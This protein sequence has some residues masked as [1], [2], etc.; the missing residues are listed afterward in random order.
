MLFSLTALIDSG[1]SDGKAA[2]GKV[3]D[4]MKILKKAG[5]KTNTY[6]PLCAYAL[7]KNSESPEDYTKIPER[8]LEL[9]KI[10]KKNHPILTSRE[11]YLLSLLMALVP[12]RTA[13]ESGFKM[14]ENYKALN[15]AGF[16]KGNQ[17][18][19]MSHILTLDKG[20]A[21]I[22]AGKCA[23]I[24]KYLKENK[25][26]VSSYG[27]GSLALLTILSMKSMDAVEKVVEYS[28]TLRKTKGFRTIGKYERLLHATALTGHEL[29]A[30][31]NFEMITGLTVQTLLLAQQIAIMAAIVVVC[32]SSSASAAS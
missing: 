8:G 25:I 19:F 12:G 16:M 17:L 30:D 11:D 7:E 9:F 20:D 21:Q 24:R 14:E 15:D 29:S 10:M 32:A 22:K 26:R 3:V 1:F 28:Q 27:D 13:G 18:Q 4:A 23:E 31:S 5:Y 6:L 2:A